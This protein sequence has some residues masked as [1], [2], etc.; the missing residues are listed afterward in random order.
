M[1]NEIPQPIAE[2]IKF[3][4]AAC[5]DAGKHGAQES[6]SVSDAS[7][8]LGFA[9]GAALAQLESKLPSWVKVGERLPTEST[10]VLATFANGDIEINWF[11]G[12]DW[13][14]TD[15]GD[16]PTHWMPLR[17]APKP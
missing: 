8:E 5:Y 10:H 14:G 13:W 6:S 7:N 3:F 4:A 17:E 15:R 12:G 1:S 2:A 16:E 9:I 11:E